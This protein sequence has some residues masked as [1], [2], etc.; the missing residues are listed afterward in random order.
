ML[1]L[2]DLVCKA[3]EQARAQLQVCGILLDSKAVQA[4]ARRHRLACITPVV[5]LLSSEDC[6]DLTGVALPGVETENESAAASP[7]KV[8]VSALVTELVLCTKEVNAKTRAQ[9]YALLVDVARALHAAHPPQPSMDG[10][11][12]QVICDC[13]LPYMLCLSIHSCGHLCLCSHQCVQMSNVTIHCLHLVRGWR[14]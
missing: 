12:M 9:A 8:V 5:L 13:D 4:A 2:L 3:A 10:G 1:Q 7:D 11:A 6:P 14:R